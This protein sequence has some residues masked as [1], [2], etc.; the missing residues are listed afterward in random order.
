M[1]FSARVVIVDD[2]RDDNTAALLALC[3]HGEGYETAVLRRAV[4][5]LTQALESACPAVLLI[6]HLHQVMA[7]RTPLAKACAAGRIGIVLTT[8]A[9]AEQ[10]PRLAGVAVLRKPFSFEALLATIAGAIPRVRS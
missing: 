7:I 4:D 5:G 9:P 1:V 6:A 2:R 3:L 10:V 8:G